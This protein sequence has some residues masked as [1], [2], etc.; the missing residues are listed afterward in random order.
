MKQVFL[1]AAALTVLVLILS[2]V[3]CKSSST[4]AT[5]TSTAISPGKGEVINSDSTNT[6]QIIGIT[7]QTTGYPWLLQVVI[8]S[9]ANVGTL[10][11][12]VAL[13][14]GD[15][16][17]VVTDQDMSKFNVNDIVTAKIKL[18]GDVNIPGGIRLYLYNA[19]QQ[20]SP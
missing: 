6:V 3:A 2:A 16:V 1:T 13:S 20:A 11:N 17:T 8:E 14:V 9:T 4:T 12:P 5:S 18:A 15:I 10:P 7:A 19:A